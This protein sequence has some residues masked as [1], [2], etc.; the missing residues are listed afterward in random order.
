MPSLANDTVDAED[1]DAMH[2]SLDELLL[3]DR[4]V[5]DRSGSKSGTGFGI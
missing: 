2:C 1:V 4:T 5:F 3:D